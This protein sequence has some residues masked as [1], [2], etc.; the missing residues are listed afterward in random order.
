M[1]RSLGRLMDGWVIDEWMNE[2]VD[3]WMDYWI[4]RWIIE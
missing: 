3:S 2:W 1:D 4:D